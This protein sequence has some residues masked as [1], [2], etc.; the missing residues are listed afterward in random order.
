MKTLWLGSII[1]AINNSIIGLIGAE[2]G[3]FSNPY[4]HAEILNLSRINIALM[5][6]EIV[7]A[8]FQIIA[9]YTDAVHFKVEN[10]NI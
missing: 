10:A 3:M 2:K 9:T 7:N 1:K 6:D 5:Q 8:G 4:L